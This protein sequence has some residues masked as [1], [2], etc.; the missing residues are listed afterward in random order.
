MIIPPVY[1]LGVLSVF[2]VSL[3]VVIKKN[4]S[5]RYEKIAWI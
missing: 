1:R 3:L 4:I 2:V 5:R